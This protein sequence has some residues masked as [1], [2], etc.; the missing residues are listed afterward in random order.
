[1]KRGL[2]I[3]AIATLTGT[4]IGAGFL[5]IP[6]VAA[7]SGFLTG[8]IHIIALGLIMLLINLYLGEIALRTKGFHQ[9]P[10]YAKKYFGKTGAV[11]MFF[12]MIFGIYTAVIAYLLGEGQSLSFIFFG[13]IKYA[14]AFSIAFFALISFL[15]YRGIETLKKGETIGLIAVL[16][17]IALIIIFFAPQVNMQNLSYAAN[18]ATI[19]FPYGVVLFAFLA[20]SVLPELERE[21]KGNE[22]L[23]KKAIIIGSVIPI[24]L[25]LLFTAVVVGF[26]GNATPEIATMAL[27]KLPTLLAVFTMF[28]ACF[29]LS[30]ALKNMYIYDLK[31]KKINAW[32]LAC[33]VPLIVFLAITRYHLMGFV[34]LLG[35][36]G[37]VAGGVAGIVIAVM[38]IKAKKLGDRKPE[39]R[40]PIN[41]FIATLLI[42]LFA[43]GIAYQFIF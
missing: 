23:M 13:T 17:I 20:F 28:T 34:K 15:V 19:F 33:F 21:L 8:A 14:L 26:A 4:I 24:I 42:A 32:L 31:F 9:L 16:S 29:A 39:Y 1:M 41:W 35:L 11:L 27:G 18:P 2:L 7:K 10:G 30:T 38:A 37:S 3:A 22:H 43:F 40:I 5:G 36:S 12:S 25:Y 6:Y